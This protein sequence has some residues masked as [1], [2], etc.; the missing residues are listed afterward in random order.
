MHKLK[1]NSSPLKDTWLEVDEFRLLFEM[2]TISGLNSLL[3]FEGV[4]GQILLHLP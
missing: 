3:I 1:F 2:V 4:S